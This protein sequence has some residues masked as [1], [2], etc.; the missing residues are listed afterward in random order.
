MVMSVF[1]VRGKKR[2]QASTGLDRVAGAGL[3]TYGF[4]HLLVAWLA[5]RIAFGQ[6][7]NASGTGALRTLAQNGPGRIILYV[8]AIGLFALALWQVAEAWSGQRDEDGLMRTLMRL[9]SGAKAVVYAALGISGLRIAAG[10]GSSSGTDSATATL[11][12]Q[13]AGQALVALVGVVIVVIGG[14]LAYWG[15][16]DDFMKNLDFGGRTGKDGRAYRWLGRIGYVTKAVAFG[17]VGALFVWAGVTHDPQHSGGLDQALHKVQQQPFGPALLVA[18]A[19]GIGC[20]GLFC[21]A[22]ARHLDR[23]GPPSR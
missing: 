9:A 1:G 5:A 12:G 6:G 13:P 4:V 19:V 17:L 10:S 2:R 22:W 21:F 23:A 16:T 18:I 7:G 8:V 15:V 3:V 20:F 14:V 11:M